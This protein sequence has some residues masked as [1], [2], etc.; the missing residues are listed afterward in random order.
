MQPQTLYWARGG[1]EG[2]VPFPVLF[3]AQHPLPLGQLLHSPEV[4]VPGTEVELTPRLSSVTC[5]CP[6]ML[7]K[8]CAY[9]CACPQMHV[10]IASMD[11]ER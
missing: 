1:L 4:R 9:L 8:G 6:L 5:V 10:Q 2:K 7:V 11:V 3:A